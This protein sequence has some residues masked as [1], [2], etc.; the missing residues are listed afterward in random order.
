MI[1]NKSNVEEVEENPISCCIMDRLIAGSC[2]A[3]HDMSTYKVIEIEIKGFNFRLCDSCTRNLKKQ[4]T[5]VL[6]RNISA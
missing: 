3:C 1:L 6:M 4:L 2:N 5:N